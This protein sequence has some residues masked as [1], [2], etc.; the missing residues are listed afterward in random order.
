MRVLAAEPDGDVEGFLSGEEAWC[1]GDLR[2]TTA[3]LGDW[4]NEDEARS[5]VGA[6]VRRGRPGGYAAARGRDR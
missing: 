5:L 2:L 6:V 4:Q 1:A 3:R